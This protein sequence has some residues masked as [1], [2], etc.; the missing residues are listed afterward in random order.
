M[1]LAL[2]NVIVGYAT[3]VLVESVRRPAPACNGPHDRVKTMW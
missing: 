1:P 2:T 3:S